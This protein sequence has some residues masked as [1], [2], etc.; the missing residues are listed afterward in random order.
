MT[1]SP[2]AWLTSFFNTPLWR[3]GGV[4]ITLG[5]TIGILILFILV[6]CLTIAFKS[7]LKNRLLKSIGFGKISLLFSGM[8]RCGLPNPLILPVKPKFKLYFIYFSF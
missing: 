4:S 5:W 3:A 7:L 8:R 1:F 6:T 2:S